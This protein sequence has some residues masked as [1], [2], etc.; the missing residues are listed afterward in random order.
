MRVKK[1]QV[2]Q[3]NLPLIMGFVSD[4]RASDPIDVLVDRVGQRITV[5][6]DDAPAEE[7]TVVFDVNAAM[8]VSKGADLK[9]IGSLLNA[10]TQGNISGLGT[11]LQ[12]GMAAGAGIGGATIDT[13]TNIMKT[14]G[15]QGNANFKVEMNEID[16][17]N[18]PV[19]IS[20][21]S[22]VTGWTVTTDTDGDEKAVVS[23]TSKL[24]S[25]AGDKIS[26]D[27]VGTSSQLPIIS[28][29][30]TAVAKLSTATAL[31]LCFLE[32]NLNTDGA[33][34]HDTV[35]LIQL[36]SISMVLKYE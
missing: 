22:T 4:I 10:V 9:N 26:T 28:K 11:G 30:S 16:I 17:A 35:S 8:A 7:V 29:D 3:D 14:T 23:Y 19:K 25:A 36:A 12:S 32:W 34:T 20:V 24:L 33:F 1:S 5:S 21:S 15:D 27:N 6:P 2:I 18:P 13:V 31:G